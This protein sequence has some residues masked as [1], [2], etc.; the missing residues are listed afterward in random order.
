[1]RE[2]PI[3]SKIDGIASNKGLISVL[4]LTV[5]AAWVPGDIGIGVP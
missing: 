2:D 4:R 5:P 3:R 1:M